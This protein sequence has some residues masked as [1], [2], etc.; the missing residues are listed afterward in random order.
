MG[1][2]VALV[3]GLGGGVLA[4]G[5]GQTAGASS[6]PA[7]RYLAVTPRLMGTP[8]FTFTVNTTADT[9]DANNGD[10]VCADSG[11]QCSLRAAVEEANASNATTQVNVPAG[12]YTL[13]I[14][15][16]LMVNDVGGLSITGAG[17]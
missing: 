5:L 1:A 8:A 3:L 2:A 13:T 12:T 6:A 14:G 11:G 9:H 16:N 10:G 17:A 4:V 15:T 7:V